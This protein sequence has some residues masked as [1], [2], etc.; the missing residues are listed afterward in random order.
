[1]TGEPRGRHRAIADP[2]AGRARHLGG[3]FAAAAVLAVVGC[4]LLT[5]AVAR[6][7]GPPPSPEA[8]PPAPAGSRT[9]ATALARSVPVQVTIPTIGVKSPLMTLGINADR[10]LQVPPLSRAGTAG[11]YRHSPTPGQ[12][13]PAIIVGHVDSESGPAV[14]YELSSLRPG[15]A[16]RVR[17]ADGVVAVFTVDRVVAFSKDDFPTGLVYGD[18][19]HSGLRL[20]TCGGTYEPDTGGYEDNTVAFASLDR[21]ES[22]E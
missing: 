6:G 14:F 21:I 8:G 19:D 3:A 10:T 5:F 7:D 18:I 9:D 16:V 12:R 2:V 20:I 11:W 15:D 4:A 13:G 1:M 17:R 22:A